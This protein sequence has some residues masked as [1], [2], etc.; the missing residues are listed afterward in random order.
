M[1]RKSLLWMFALGLIP[2]AA[3]AEVRPHALCSDGMVLQQ[4]SNVK[5]WG[6]AD[7]GEK[8][9][10]SFRGKS[11]SAVADAGGTASLGVLLTAGTYRLVISGEVRDQ[12]QP[13]PDLGYSLNGMIRTDPIGPEVEDTTVVPAVDQS[14]T[15]VVVRLI[16][17]HRSTPRTGT[18]STSLL[19]PPLPSS[20]SLCVA[21]TPSSTWH[22]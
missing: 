7:K 1:V 3:R 8:V 18:R 16:T 20:L 13:M 14:T 21:S 11:A 10:V 17:S 15:A 12:S 6:T 19:A 9:D 2:A 22:G 4:M 5:I